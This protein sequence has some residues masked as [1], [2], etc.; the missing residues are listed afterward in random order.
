MSICFFTVPAASTI[1][2]TPRNKSN[3]YVQLPES[4]KTFADKR[5]ML[6][7]RLKDEA[8]T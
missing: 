4:R 6:V 7:G 1:K 2:V 3:V 8:C 5:K